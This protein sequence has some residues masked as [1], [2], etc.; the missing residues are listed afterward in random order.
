MR[1]GIILIVLCLLVNVHA[2]KLFEIPEYIENIEIDKEA[3]RYKLE[4][5]AYKFKNY[6]DHII[7]KLKYDRSEYLFVECFIYIC[8]AAVILAILPYATIIVVV[9]FCIIICVNTTLYIISSIKI[10]I[11]CCVFLLGIIGFLVLSKFGII[12][13]SYELV[14]NKRKYRKK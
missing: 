12:P 2:I 8:V 1:K 9:S 4:G 5:Y 3:I 7:I 10:L 13:Y 11:V 6:L 14:Y